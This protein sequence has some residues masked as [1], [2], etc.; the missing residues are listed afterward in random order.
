MFT[1]ETHTVVLTMEWAMSV[2][3]NHLDKL[4][5][6][7]KEIDD[8]VVAGKMLEDSDLQKLPYLRCIINETL[9][10]YP[11]GPLLVPHYSSK[12]CNIGGFDIPGGTTLLV[13]A[14]AIHRD[15][16]LWEDPGMF[17]PERFKGFEGD[18]MDLDLF[19]LEWG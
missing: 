17:N 5:R 18:M 19:H 15:P 3:L 7:R 13:N 9:R 8:N 1:A 2:L 6:A 16:N 14:W 12:D 11:I 10:L 4:G